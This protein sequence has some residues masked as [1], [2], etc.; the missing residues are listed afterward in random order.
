MKIVFGDGV[1]KPEKTGNIYQIRL[2]LKQNYNIEINNN[3]DDTKDEI[4]N[5][6]SNKEFLEESVNTIDSVNE[7]ILSFQNAFTFIDEVDIETSSRMVD[8]TLIITVYDYE[9]LN[10]ILSSS[11]TEL[12]NSYDDEALEQSALDPVIKHIFT[13]WQINQSSEDYNISFLDE[14]GDV[15]LEQKVVL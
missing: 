6:L 13:G 7:D 5:L 4:I 8:I 10:N 11:N 2:Q 12:L 14:T 1:K 15:E 3:S 9:S